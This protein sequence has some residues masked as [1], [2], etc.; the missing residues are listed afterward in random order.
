MVYDFVVDK[1]LGW[2]VAG[3]KVTKSVR[4]YYKLNQSR[5]YYSTILFLPL[6]AHLL[7][8]SLHL[9]VGMWAVKDGQTIRWKTDRG[10]HAVHC[11]MFQKVRACYILRNTWEIL[12][13]KIYV[14]DHKY[15]TNLHLNWVT[16]FKWDLCPT[17]VKF[18]G[19]S[20]TQRGQWAEARS[21]HSSESVSTLPLLE[22]KTK[23]QWGM[24]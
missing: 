12:F 11:N 13:Y 21:G 8:S 2:Q 5:K 16:V 6:S 14:C 3:P 19:L 17:E 23:D 24:N 4:V 22:N 18:T 1:M 15:V 20:E 7:P 9:P 10:R